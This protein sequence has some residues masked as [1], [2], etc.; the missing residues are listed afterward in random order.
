MSQ[1]RMNQQQSSPDG[2]TILEL[3]D[4]CVYFRGESGGLRS[5][6][7]IVRAVDDV[8][9]KLYETELLALVGES[10]SGK[11]TVARTI[12]G[13]TK[14]TSGTVLHR[15]SEVDKLQG[16]K[17]QEYLRDV[18][19]V[20]QDPFES[21]YPRFDVFTIISTPIVRLL[22]EKNRASLEKAVSDLLIELGLDPAVYMHRLPHQLSGGERQRVSIARALASNPKLLVADEPVTMVDASQRFNILSLIKILQEKRNLSV[23]LITHDLASAKI[24]GNRIA[25]MYKGK[26]VEIGPAQ[27]V[28]SKPFHPYM[29]MIIEATPTLEETPETF[30]A[31]QSS[32]DEKA[33]TE[34]CVFRARCKYATE[35]C[36]TV[37]PKLIEREEKHSV[38]CHN[39]LN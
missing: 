9:I 13:L 29:E 2:N 16:E 28:L 12:A 11:T 19:I 34:G 5:K 38:A 26:I 15:G 39:P 36:K 27:T 33:F 8:S 32:Q 18:Q 10:G 35:T 14:P 23:L 20:F 30:G 17:L 7:N 3:K 21:L 1:V 6:P 31:I 37:E 22:G 25:L 24:M 4:L